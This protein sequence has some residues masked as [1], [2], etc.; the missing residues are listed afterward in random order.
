MLQSLNG[1]IL[2]KLY[3]GIHFHMSH[4]MQWHVGIQVHHAFTLTLWS[5]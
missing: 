5:S 1:N 4:L 3:V 2:G